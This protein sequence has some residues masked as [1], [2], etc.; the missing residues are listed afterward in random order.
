LNDE[1]S[2]RQNACRGCE[3][4]SEDEE[5]PGY[6]ID[7]AMEAE[8]S[9]LIDEEISEEEIQ[10]RRELWLRQQQEHENDDE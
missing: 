8:N 1:L 10:R 7:D 4:P 9:T 2:F 3:V 5:D 6:A